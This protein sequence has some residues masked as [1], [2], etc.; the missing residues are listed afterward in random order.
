VLQTVRVVAVAT[1]GGP[2]RWLWV[3]SF[4]GFR[5]KGPEQG[6]WVES[7]GTDFH[8]IRLLDYTPL[9]G[10]VFIQ[11]EYNILEIHRFSFVKKLKAPLLNCIEG[12]GII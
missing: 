4:P 9:F 8:I 11:F 1:I 7:P 3:G 12:Y 6:R 2:A 10:P 5:S